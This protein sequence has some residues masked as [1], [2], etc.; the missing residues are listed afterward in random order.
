[1]SET[2]ARQHAQRLRRLL[3]GQTDPAASLPL[4]E[5]LRSAEQT[6]ASEGAAPATPDPS[7]IIL[8]TT[9]TAPKHQLSAATT[10]LIA[11]VKLRMSQ[12][13]GSIVH[14]LDAKQHPLVEVSV[15]NGQTDRPR[16][17]RVTTFV[18]GYSARA[19]DSIEL[20]IAAPPHVFV[21]LPTFFPQRLA[22]LR[23]LTRASVRVRVENLDGSIELENSAAVWISPPSTALMTV[24]DPAS[25]TLI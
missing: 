19:V 25:G 21:Q 20:P 4:L 14:L 24:R 9:A 17:V 23:E 8:S 5:A 11:Q 3:H 6:V 16:R 15:Q 22:P 1:M 2:S 18:E 12:I 10:G 7:A 13:P